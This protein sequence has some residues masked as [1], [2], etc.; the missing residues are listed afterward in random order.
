MPPPRD[1]GAAAAAGTTPAAERAACTPA[2][3]DDDDDDAEGLGAAAFANTPRLWGLD[4]LLWSPSW[5]LVCKVLALRPHG[6]LDDVYFHRSNRPVRVVTVLG[7]V[8]AVERRE[9]MII[10]HVD[11][12]TGVLA[13]VQWLDPAARVPVLSSDRENSRFRIGEL[14]RCTGQ[15][16]DFHGERQINLF[17]IGASPCNPGISF[18]W[19]Q[20][21]GLTGVWR[22]RADC[23][24]RRPQRTAFVVASSNETFQTGLRPAVPPVE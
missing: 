10:R 18:P 3:E 23:T 9:K 5:L 12:G 16:T 24:R 17:S 20:L 7:T 21:N 15:L 2:D 13:C 1:A 4:P 8:V 19:E 22:R 11:D 14:V 6:D